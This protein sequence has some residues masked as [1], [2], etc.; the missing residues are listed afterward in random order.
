[1]FSIFSLFLENRILASFTSFVLQVFEYDLN[2]KS[3]SSS[4]F[5]S[6]IS[7]C[8]AIEDNFLKYEVSHPWMPTCQKNLSFFNSDDVVSQPLNAWKNRNATE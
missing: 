3:P 5:S 6:L 2:T 7:C 4:N 8:V 1:M